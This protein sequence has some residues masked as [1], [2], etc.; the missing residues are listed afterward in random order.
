M[1]CVFG[2]DTKLHV[3]FDIT[4][5]QPNGSTV[6]SI[7]RSAAANQVTAK[8]LIVLVKEFAKSQ[9]IN[10]ASTGT[11]SS[12]AYCFLCIYFL[13]K[14]KMLPQVPPGD[15]FND[16]EKIADLLGEYQISTL[17]FEPTP[18]PL[19]SDLLYGFFRFYTQEFDFTVY[20]ISL[21]HSGLV[22]YITHLL[23]IFLFSSH[24]L[25][26]MFK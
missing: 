10:S 5:N 22:R 7:V 8:R 21:S 13:I 15:E 1:W 23:F 3:K 17:T 12:I 11:L 14:C 2:R 20:A 25:C 24:I 19:L 9:D 18:Y 6:T 4:L 16:A 26:P